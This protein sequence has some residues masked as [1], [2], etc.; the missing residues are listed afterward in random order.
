[1]I[2]LFDTLK[3]IVA[4]AAAW[5]VAHLIKFAVA[6]ARRDYKTFFLSGGMPSAHS[7][8]IVSV[9][10][11]VGLIEGIG[12]ATFAVAFAA[13]LIVTYD[14]THVRQMAARTTRMLNTMHSEAKDTVPVHNGH[15]T[16]E[17]IAGSILGG[18]VAVVVFFAT[19]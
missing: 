3:Y 6:L 16:S 5:L 14:A 17:V 10:T 4:I 8:V 7:A 15:T 2:D 18:L 13:A 11:L 12:S 19:K 1:V 9:A